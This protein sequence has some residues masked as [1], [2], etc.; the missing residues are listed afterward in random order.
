MPALAAT[1]TGQ[2]AAAALLFLALIVVTF[3][4]ILACWLWPFVAC[5]RCKGTGKRRALFGGKAFGIC[6]RCD[7]TG[8][9][10]RPGRRAI[11]Y[12]RTVRANDRNRTGGNR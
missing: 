10:L 4:Y 12:L 9:Q 2:P 1:A 5:R 6:R 11:N 8:R 7:G 3:G